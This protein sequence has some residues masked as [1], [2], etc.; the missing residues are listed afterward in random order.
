M[1][2]IELISLFK[3]SK[4]IIDFLQR[5]GAVEISAHE[6]PENMT[7]IDTEVNIS[8]LEKIRTKAEKAREVLGFYAP[9]K[10]S[11]IDSFRPP[12]EI[13]L[14]EYLE[15]EAVCDKAYTVCSA[16]SEADKKITDAKAEIIRLE[17]TNSSISIWENLDVPMK[18][19]PTKYTAL[20]V[21]SFPSLQDE[22]SVKEKLAEIAPNIEA[23]ETEII[24]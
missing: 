8:Q 6:E 19:K 20:I 5:K 10:S 17:T 23:Y 22:G 15:K 24:Y 2:K 16:I 18:T 12:R 1:L 11:I 14:K 4:D 9:Q 7:H 13:S 21:G 3:N